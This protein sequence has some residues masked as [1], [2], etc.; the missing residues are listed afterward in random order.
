MI[1][2]NSKRSDEIRRKYIQSF[3]NTDSSYYIE[4]IDKLTEFCDGLC[5]VGYLWDCFIK[6]QVVSESEILQIL[7]EKRNIYI[8]WDIHTCERIFIP[9]YWKYPKTSILIVEEWSSEIQKD[10]PEDIYLFDDSFTWSAIYTHET[11]VNETR[12]CIY[13]RNEKEAFDHIT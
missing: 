6:P 9:N 7:K 3:V 10:L 1:A 13:I 4:K 2:L 8:M 11:D 12:Y 5:Y